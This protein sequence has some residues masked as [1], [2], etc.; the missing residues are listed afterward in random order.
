MDL[1]GGFT[2]TFNDID[3]SSQTNLIREIYVDDDFLDR[4]NLYDDYLTVY[5]DSEADIFTQD[6]VKTNVDSTGKPVYTF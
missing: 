6:Y 2:V 1:T 3:N 4:P 5:D